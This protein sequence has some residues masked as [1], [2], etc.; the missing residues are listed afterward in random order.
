MALGSRTPGAILVLLACSYR[1]PS[2][3]PQLLTQLRP[4]AVCVGS[5]AP[6]GCL[7][8]Q[9]KLPQAAPSPPEG[10]GESRARTRVQPVRKTHLSSTTS[11]CDFGKQP[12]PCQVLALLPV[13]GDS[14]DWPIERL[15][16]SLRQ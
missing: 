6:E 2:N 3:C 8:S 7:H 16:V 15:V 1:S 11:W 5:S 14:T 13:Y 4:P 9:A 10:K 12:G